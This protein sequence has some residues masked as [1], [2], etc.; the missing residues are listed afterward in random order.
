[1]IEVGYKY[2]FFG[3]DAENASRVLGI[4]AHIVRNFVTA[5]IPSYRLNFHVRQL[6]MAGYKVG[7]VKQ[8]ETSAIKSHGVKHVGPFRREL[9]AL[10]TRSTIDTAEDLGGDGGEDEGLGGCN[11]NYLFCIVEQGLDGNV[12]NANGNFDV[13]IGVVAVEISTGDVM[14]GEFNDN[15]TRSGLEATVSKLS[16]TE[17]LLGNPLSIATEKVRQVQRSIKL[18]QTRQTN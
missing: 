8:T 4:F 6:V 7:V 15:V 14:H 1:M 12:Y 5:S 2:C 17:I 11:A 9:S 13:K 18:T 16:P 10:Y 3:E